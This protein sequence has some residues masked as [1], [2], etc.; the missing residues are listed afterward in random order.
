[1]AAVKTADHIAVHHVNHRLG[2]GTGNALLRQ[3]ALLHDGFAHW[4]TVVGHGQLG[5]RGRRQRQQVFDIAHRQHARAIATVVGL[6]DDKRLLVDAVFL[7]L[8]PNF[9]QHR[10]H[11]ALQRVQ[12]GVGGKV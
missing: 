9:G 1:M 8:A 12:P 2:D 4:L 7:V 10:V 5:A 3:H 6:N 11:R